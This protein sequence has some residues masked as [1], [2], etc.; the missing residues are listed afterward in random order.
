[1]FALTMKYRDVAKAVGLRNNRSNRKYYLE[2]LAL[3]QDTDEPNIS[4]YLGESQ[5]MVRYYL[6][7][8]FFL[9]SSAFRT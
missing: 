4:E 2:A 1:M 5:F 8:F 7:L 6:K 3:C 9:F